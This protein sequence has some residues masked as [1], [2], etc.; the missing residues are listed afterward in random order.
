MSEN[1]PSFEPRTRR[2]FFSNLTLRERTIL[3]ILGAA[4]I[5]GMA[6]GAVRI[7][8]ARRSAEPRPGD[9]Y[10][11]LEAAL[12]DR[13][14]IPPLPEP[15]PGE[16]ADRSGKIYLTRPPYPDRPE[17]EIT[18][19]GWIFF[20]RDYYTTININRAGLDQ[21]VAL[22][23]IGPVTAWRIINYR[24]RYVGFSRLKAL[25]KVKGI[26]DKTLKRLEGKIRLY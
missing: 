5:W 16:R 26:G 23:G 4:L 19:D 2:T 7:R 22:P 24:K 13:E 3:G 10:R 12:P 9:L 15:G 17:V 18:E 11:R 8:R 6:G 14:F 20:P 1:F 25:K 21:L